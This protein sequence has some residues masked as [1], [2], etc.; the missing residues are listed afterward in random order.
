[1]CAIDALGI[2]AM[3]GSDATI[4]STDP[5]TGKVIHIRLAGGRAEW[6]PASAVVFYGARPEKGPS[7]SVCCGYLR[8]FATSAGAREFAEAHP[9]AEGEILDQDAAQRLGEEIF[10]PLL[11]E[12]AAS[13]ADGSGPAGVG[14]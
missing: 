9:E 13:V 11:A 6:E 1:M 12:S 2:P 5:I 10:G 4:S 3:L 7:A 14:P 8:F